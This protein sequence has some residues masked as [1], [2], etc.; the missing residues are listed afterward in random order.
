MNALL[1]PRDDNGDLSRWWLR[2][3]AVVMVF[4]FAILLIITVLTY[5]NAPPIPGKVVDTQGQTLFTRADVGA[6][7]SI[8]LKY[9]LMN[10]G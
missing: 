1:E 3:I 9:G 6:G 4:G 10:N 2:A 8:F 5:R 7:Q